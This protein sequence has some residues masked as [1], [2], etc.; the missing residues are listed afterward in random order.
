MRTSGKAPAGGRVVGKPDW[1]VG[2]LP[3]YPGPNTPTQQLRAFGPVLV[4][5]RGRWSTGSPGFENGS[6]AVALSNPGTAVGVGRTRLR[7]KRRRQSHRLSFLACGSSQTRPVQSRC[8]LAKVLPTHIT[9]LGTRFSLKVPAVGFE[10]W[11]SG[12]NLGHLQTSSP[13]V[14]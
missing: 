7:K 6:R 4:T 5:S 11:I 12:D 14:N 3:E 8:S 1:R 2:S 10:G 13:Q 9:R